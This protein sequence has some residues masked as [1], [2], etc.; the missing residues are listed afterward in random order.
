MAAADRVQCHLL[1]LSRQREGPFQT[2]YRR[3]PTYEFQL[4]SVGLGRGVGRVWYLLHTARSYVIL[5][6]RTSPAKSLRA[7]LC[8][9]KP[10]ERRDPAA[11]GRFTFVLPPT[12]TLVNNKTEGV[13]FITEAPFGFFVLFDGPNSAVNDFCGGSREPSVIKLEDCGCSRQRSRIE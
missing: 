2:L 9:T 6:R 3:H 8:S 1:H 11:W 13:S 4:Y 7:Y 12:C 10:S 5:P